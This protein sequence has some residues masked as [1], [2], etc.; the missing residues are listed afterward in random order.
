MLACYIDY[1]G[2]Q[3]KKSKTS[4]HSLALRCL[5]SSETTEES[6]SK[7]C[8]QGL[9]KV[10][11]QTRICIHSGMPSI[12]T[13][14]KLKCMEIFSIVKLCLLA[15]LYFSGIWLDMFVRYLQKHCKKPWGA[16][17]KAGIH[18]LPF[19]LPPPLPLS[20]CVNFAQQG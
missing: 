1:L 6:G 10:I 11:V 15:L 18:F 14:S 4:L 12:K 3:L 17:T 5:A 20:T 7:K 9:L 13:F 16:F 8:Y 19:F 2:S